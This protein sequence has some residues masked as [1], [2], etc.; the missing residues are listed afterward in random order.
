[1]DG[2]AESLNFLAG[3]LG[4]T[5]ACPALQTARHHVVGA[6]LAGTSRQIIEDGVWLQ[7]L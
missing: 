4:R 3:Y 6:D 5:A 2:Y 1:M 7:G